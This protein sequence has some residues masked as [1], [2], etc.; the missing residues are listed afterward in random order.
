MFECDI[1]KA[2]FTRNYGLKLHMSKK[3]P[4][5][6][7]KLNKTCINCNKEFSTVRTY[8]YHCDGRCKIIKNNIKNDP[9]EETVKK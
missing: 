6:N 3:I 9:L 8:K 1:C 2:T 4:C 5:V 7:K